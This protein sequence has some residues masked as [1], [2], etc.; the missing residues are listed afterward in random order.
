VT[1]VM[2]ITDIDDK[3]IAGALHAKKG[4]REYTDPYTAAFFEDLEKLNI[5]KV[6]HY[7]RAT[8]FIPQ[9][10]TLIQTLIDKNMAYKGGDGSI[11]FS[12][13]KFPSYGCLSHL[14]LG[15]LKAGASERVGTD[16][17][18]KENVADFVLWKAY[19]YERDGAIYWESPFG[20]GRPGWHIECSAM[21]MSLLG[22]T[23]DIHVGGVD[24]MFPHHENE[25]A[26]SEGCTGSPFVHIWLHCEHLLV[27]NKKMSKSLGNF[28]TL[29]DLFNKG[30]T[31][32]EVRFMLLSAHYKTQLNF[33]MEGLEAA[34]ATLT[35]L[36]DFIERLKSYEGESASED[37]EVLIKQTRHTFQDSLFDDLNSAS[38]QGALFEMVRKVNHLCDEKKLS[39]HQAHQI[40]AFLK[41]LDSV[42]GYIPL[43]KEE[44]K[45]PKHL[46][47]ALEKREQARRKKNWTDADKFRDEILSS[48]Y[49]IEDTPSGARLKKKS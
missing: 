23:L 17:Y 42:L 38:A 4:L 8:D 2:N 12:I 35:R 18:D 21:A 37:V 10:I 7:P 22:Q 5:E 11:Y 6:E 15:E 14:K 19:D 28:Y 33:T 39:R 44:I 26:Q 20:K 16:E 27:G 40:L 34:R 36:S 41:E 30:Y 45:V 48:G 43:E 13:A 1:Q 3:T 47:E 46:L 29:R 49:L 31:G 32:Q 24:N 25:I 9:M